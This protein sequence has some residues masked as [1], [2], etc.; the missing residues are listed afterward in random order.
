[1][2]IVIGLP[3]SGGG[4]S[5]KFVDSIMFCLTGLKANFTW[6]RKRS[7]LI[8]VSR[9]EMFQKARDLDADYLIMIDSDI[10][11]PHDAIGK[12]I[13]HEKDICSGVYYMRDYPHR[14]YVYRWTGKDVYVHENY[15]Q[16][17][18]ELFK[19]DSVGGGFLLISKKVL[20]GWDYSW[21]KPFNHIEH[22][23]G[24]GGRLLG[25]DTSFC[26]R[27]KDRF[28]IWADPT[29]ELG[30]EGDI[31]IGRKHW[32]RER[33]KMLDKDR[34]SDGIDGWTTPE[35]LQ[36]LAEIASSKRNIVEV[37]SW[38]GRSTKVLLDASEG[39]VHAVDHFE[40]TDKEGDDWSG[41]LA[42][43]QDVKSEF[44]KNVG[45][46]HNLR[47]HEMPSERAVE[48]F[49]DGE[50]DM[51][52]IDGDHTYTGCK[53]DI[54]MWLPKIAKGGLICGHDYANGWDG[55]VR[56]V[57][58]TVGDVNVVGTIWYKEVA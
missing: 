24:D 10:E 53:R 36:F 41:I 23:D 3:H 35:E 26:L 12:L 32:E 1:M 49:S 57:S 6:L 45:E 19:V 30:H 18:E 46:Y 14:P 7:A 44:I 37:G 5:G 22:D 54:E 42:K 27:C 34:Q 4:F 50:L 56:A 9:N 40:G 39:F 51:V 13:A 52:F 8:Y 2:H 33:K 29:I 11:F 20:Q 17:P 31:T 15:S 25:E 58:D 47:L 55:V 48:L 21:G 28:E 43:E 38:K 16:V